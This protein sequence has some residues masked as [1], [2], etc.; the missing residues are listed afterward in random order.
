MC[1]FVDLPLLKRMMV[2][3]PFLPIGS[4]V[5]VGSMVGSYVYLNY[6]FE[7]GIGFQKH[8]TVMRSDDPRIALYRDEVINAEKHASKK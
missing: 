7:E 3:I 5:A 4:V 8:F 6:I 2:E 1:S